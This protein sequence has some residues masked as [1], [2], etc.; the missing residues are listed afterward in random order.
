MGTGLSFA[1]KKELLS[2]EAFVDLNLS[3][4]TIEAAIYM[5]CFAVNP[6]V[7]GLRNS[8]IRNEFRSMFTRLNPIST[9][10]SMVGKSTKFDITQGQSQS[11]N[12]SKSASHIV[13]SKL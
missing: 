6:Y 5:T 9:V 12:R 7:Y 13:V 10:R 4:W 2:C 1:Y 3:L 8:D 11:R